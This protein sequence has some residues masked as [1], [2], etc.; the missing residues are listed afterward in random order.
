MH[1]IPQNITRHTNDLLQHWLLLRGAFRNDI[2]HSLLPLP[3]TCPMAAVF[4]PNLP[5]CSIFHTL[6]LYAIFI[7]GRQK[8]EKEKEKEERRE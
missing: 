3:T 8:K 5:E 7:C 4:E 1:Y 6:C 2:S